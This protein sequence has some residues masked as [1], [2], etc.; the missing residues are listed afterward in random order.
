MKLRRPSPALVISI[1]ALVV[2]CTGTAVAASIITS[3]AQIKN[4]IVTGSDIKNGTIQNGDIKEGTITQARL[5]KGVS[6]KLDGGSS[7]VVYE[8]IRHTGPENQPQDQVVQ[9]ATLKVPAGA[10]SISAKTVMSAII[11]P[12]NLV[13]QLVQSDLA[14]GGRCKLNTPGDTDESLT[15]IIINSRQTPATLVMQVTGTFGAPAVITLDCSAGR[16]FRLS[17]TSIIAQKVGSIQ[18]TPI[19]G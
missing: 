19:A 16:P 17:E 7:T 14:I 11:G 2:A 15:N 12:Q 18:L 5:T 4:G 10:Y 3:S 1:A 9:V 8:A 13:G 6:K